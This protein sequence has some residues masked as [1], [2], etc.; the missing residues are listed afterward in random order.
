MAGED[1]ASVQFRGGAVRVETALFAAARRAT[2]LASGGRFSSDT[3]DTT[4]QSRWLVSRHWRLVRM[5]GTTIDVADTP[6]NAGV[7]GRAGTGR[8]MAA[9]SRRCG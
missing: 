4:A 6:A 9:R 2:E 5:D 7:F 3:T 8:G 1:G